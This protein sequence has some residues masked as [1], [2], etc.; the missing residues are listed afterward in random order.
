V[1]SGRGGASG[2]RSSQHPAD[3]LIRALL[4]SGRQPTT[5]EIQAIL[6]RLASAPFNPR[7][8]PVDVALVGR[9]YLGQVIP[10]RA[11]ASLAHL[12]KRV[13]IDEQWAAGT[14]VN[15]YLADLRASVLSGQIRIMIAVIRE[16]PS[17]GALAPNLTPSE[18]LGPNAGPLVFVGYSVNGGMITTGYQTVNQQSLRLPGNARWLS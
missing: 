8:I 10:A 11:E 15:Q 14:T 5:E 9:T 2:Q 16:S 13:L 4:D 18:R 7:E 17:A 1:T 12:W 3:L 6:Q